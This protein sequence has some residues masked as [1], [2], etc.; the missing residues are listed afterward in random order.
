MALDLNAMRAKLELSRNGGKKQ[1][2][3]TKWRPEEGD[4]TIRILPTPDGDPFKEFHFHY[5][6]GKNPGILCPTRN[7]NEPC[8]ICDL[9]SQRW[10]DGVENNSADSKRE[11]KKMET[12][13]LKLMEFHGFSFSQLHRKLLRDEYKR[14]NL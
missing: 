1:Q 8:P 7:Y 3:S 9:A 13:T 11:A 10:R 4:Q 5:N 14:Q 2:D 12:I 6:I